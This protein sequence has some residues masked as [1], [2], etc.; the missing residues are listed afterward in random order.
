MARG[1]PIGIRLLTLIQHAST[2]RYTKLAPDRFRGFW[3]D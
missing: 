1:D 2:V 3:K